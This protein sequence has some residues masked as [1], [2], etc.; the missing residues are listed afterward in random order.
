[1]DH[2]SYRSRVIC[3]AAPADPQ[4]ASPPMCILNV[5]G[6]A[7]VD[8]TGVRPATLVSV[9]SFVMLLSYFVLFGTAF[10]SV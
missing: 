3:T 7:F 10:V 8:G 2:Q 4:R 6:F 9:F 1:M 5:T